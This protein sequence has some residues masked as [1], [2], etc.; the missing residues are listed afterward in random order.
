MRRSPKHLNVLVGAPWL[1]GCL[2]VWLMAC[3]PNATP[4]ADVPDLLPSAEVPP[5][6]SAPRATEA[7]PQDELS[8]LV[9]GLAACPLAA[10]ASMPPEQCPGWQRWEAAEPEL[11]EQDEAKL[12]A[13][14]AHQNRLV[15]YGAADALA[16]HGARYFSELPLAEQ[17]VAQAEA[18]RD[19]DIGPNLSSL[20][21]RVDQPSLTRRIRQMLV[22]H[23]NHDLQAGLMSRGAM[24]EKGSELLASLFDKAT[25]KDKALI[26]QGLW[27]GEELHACPVFARALRGNTFAAADNAAY[28]VAFGPRCPKL[29]GSAL[30]WIARTKELPAQSMASLALGELCRTGAAQGSE[31]V[32]AAIQARRLS[33]GGA[34]DVRVSALQAVMHCDSAAGAAFVRGYLKDPEPAVQ[35]AAARLLEAAP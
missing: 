19:P 14:L 18:E 9:R 29:V 7:E 1:A 3:G 26:V 2:S 12:V 27:L 32:L 4:V 23:P 34:P 15:R 30:S 21:L 35:A 8:V 13:L 6:A 11:V 28:G 10:K 17:V 33:A 25:D 24:L 22:S 5:D 16:N 20:L 31:R